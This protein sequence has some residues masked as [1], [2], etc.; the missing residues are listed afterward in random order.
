[1]FEMAKRSR[2]GSYSEQIDG[3]LYAVVQLR[4][5]DGKYK[6]KRK[7]VTSKTEA[8][9]W[10]LEQLAANQPG[11][12]DN[13][14][15]HTF[16]ELVSWYRAHY[17]V[18]PVFANGVKIE[19]KKTH[20]ND[21]YRLN[22]LLPYFAKYPLK[23]LNEELFRDYARRRRAGEF[24]TDRQG[25]PRVVSVTAVNRDLALIRAMLRKAHEKGWINRVPKVPISMSAENKRERILTHSEERS[26]LTHCTGLREHLRAVVILAVDTGLRKGEILSL[27][28]SH[29]DFINKRITITVTNAKTERA[30]VV[31]MTPR[32]REEL[33]QI[34]EKATGEK[35]FEFADIKRAFKTACRAAGLEDF[36]FHDLRATAITRMIRAGVPHTEVMKLS[37]HS[38]MKTFMK[39]LNPK[40]DAI[41]NA[42]AMLSQLNEQASTDLE[43]D[44]V[45]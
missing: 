42:V 31:G 2:Y 5:A 4:Q 39:Y 7:L 14:P 24:R 12:I 37:G 10:A 44:S 41:A 40:G 11:M 8:R 45:N 29:L 22:L 13:S 26:L 21:R 1:M 15:K 3:K 30:R 25:K 32:I 16:A 6:K 34:T 20:Q 9:Q 36:H 23:A 28:R 43:S 17:V 38:V 19:G 27:E 35:L 18:P 33:L